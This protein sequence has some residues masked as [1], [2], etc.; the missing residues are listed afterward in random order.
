MPSSC[1]PAGSERQRWS[2]SSPALAA[3][4][5]MTA[6]RPVSMATSTRT[7][8]VGSPRKNAPTRSRNR[9]MFCSSVRKNSPV[10][11]K[12]CQRASTSPRSSAPSLVASRIR[13]TRVAVG[14]LGVGSE[15]GRQHAPAPGQLPPRRPPGQPSALTVPLSVLRAISD[16]PAASAARS[17]SQS[18]SGSTER[19]GS[20]PRLSRSASGTMNS[21]AAP[22]PSFCSNARRSALTSASASAG[23]RSSTT[24]TMMSLE[25]ASRRSFHGTASA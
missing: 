17:R 25:A 12:S 3:S 4:S 11:T 10:P 18:R 9:P 15:R 21:P 23:T 2:V 6:C 22:S 8:G 7:A 13:A 16:R 24:A 20:I 1:R 19:G 5:R 14:R